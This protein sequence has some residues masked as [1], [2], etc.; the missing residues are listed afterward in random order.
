MPTAASKARLARLHAGLFAALAICA[1]A[2]TIEVLRAVGGNTLSWAYVV[3]WPVLLAYAVYMWQRLVREERHGVA[4]TTTP[5]D[6]PD[7]AAALAAWNR[8]L[9]ELHAA[10]AAQGAGRPGGPRR[11]LT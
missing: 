6:D 2:F 11:A 10:D 1:T 7:D 3:E 5:A 9:A 4:A 8:Y